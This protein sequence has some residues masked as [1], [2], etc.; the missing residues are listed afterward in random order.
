MTLHFWPAI[1]CLFFFF[2]FLKKRD[3][4]LI[5]LYHLVPEKLLNNLA[6][7]SS[8]FVSLNI[9]HIRT[10]QTRENGS[11]CLLVPYPIREAPTCQPA[12]DWA[13]PAQSH[14][15]LWAPRVMPD[16]LKASQSDTS[17]ITEVKLSQSSDEEAFQSIYTNKQTNLQYDLRAGRVL[18]EP[19]PWL[20]FSAEILRVLRQLNTLKPSAWFSIPQMLEKLKTKIT[21]FKAGWKICS[22]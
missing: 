9:T 13:P 10:V 12:P 3:F 18:L 2:S 1:P 6:D 15:T 19:G 17:P 7:F 14:C 22:D 16:P 5:F 21:S 4:Q 11:P 20:C 8:T